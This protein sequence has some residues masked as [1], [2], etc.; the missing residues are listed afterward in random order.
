VGAEP[1]SQ[2]DA[3]VP[4]PM[5]LCLPTAIILSSTSI[6][7]FLINLTNLNFTKNRRKILEMHLCFTVPLLFF[8]KFLLA[9][10]YSRIKVEPEPNHYI[11]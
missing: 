4:S 2:R 5:T 6:K 1:E 3:T 11:V 8:F 9:V 10:Y 7:P